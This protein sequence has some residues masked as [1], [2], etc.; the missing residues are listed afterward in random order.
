VKVPAAPESFTSSVPVPMP[1]A[2]TGIWMLFLSCSANRNVEWVAAAG[3]TSGPCTST[4]IAKS[5][6]GASTLLMSIL[7]RVWSLRLRKRGKVA[8]AT[9]GSRTITSFE[10]CATLVFDQ[11]AAMTRTV[12][13]KAGRSK[14]MLAVPFEPTLTM[15]E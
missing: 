7:K 10:A 2:V 11:A 6:A 5:P 8:S 13:L 14:V 12:P 4:S 15:P 1:A 3:S 9:T